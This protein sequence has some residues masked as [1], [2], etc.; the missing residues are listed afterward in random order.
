MIFAV[1]HDGSEKMIEL[2]FIE[3]HIIVWKKDALVKKYHLKMIDRVIGSFNYDEIIIEFK[4]ESSSMICSA[5]YQAQRDI[6]VKVLAFAVEDLNFQLDRLQNK[7]T[8][9]NFALN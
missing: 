2:N 9:P 8:F 6:I 4:D 1:K 5:V 3:S 7:I